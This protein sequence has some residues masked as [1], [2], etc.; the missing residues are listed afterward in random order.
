M[1]ADHPEYRG[2][3]WDVI[4]NPA[5]DAPRLILADWLDDHGEPGRAEFIRAQ[6]EMAAFKKTELCVYNTRPHYKQRSTP[7][8]TYKQGGNCQCK[9][10]ALAK[11]E[12]QSWD[13]CY[14]QLQAE[15]NHWLRR[16][17]TL[18]YGYSTKWHL[19]PNE[20]DEL[21][22][23]WDRGFVH[24]VAMPAEA[25]ERHA[26]RLFSE[27][28]VQSVRLIDVGQPR[29]HE[30]GG[31]NDRWAWWFHLLLE[32]LWDVICPG[33]QTSIFVECGPTPNDAWEYM[34]DRLVAWG[35][36]QAASRVRNQEGVAS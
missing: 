11:R 35:R 18:W 2:L 24:K 10:D 7:C 8:M 28:P 36:E 26:A 3:L 5:D 32:G 19:S 22:T 27:H 15:V 13:V 21:V 14:H 25:F 29:C 12:S 16:P 4:D 34:S 1:T 31:G 20:G 6:C 30:Y 33:D 23:T 9:A 17:R